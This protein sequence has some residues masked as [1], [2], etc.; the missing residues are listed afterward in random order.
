[1][2]IIHQFLSLRMFKKFD[3]CKHCSCAD[4][5][6]LVLR[7]VLAAVLVMHGYQKLFGGM[8]MFVGF[9]DKLQ[10]PMPE[11]L[12]WIVA[13]LE[14]VGGIAIAAGVYTRYV[15]AAVAVQFAVILLVVKKLAFPSSDTDLLVFGIA[16]ALAMVG[17]GSLSCDAK[18]M[19]GGSKESP[20]PAAGGSSM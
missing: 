10:F 14:F 1:M 9:L 17:A 18:F 4:Q 16:M 13:L 20:T 8:P 15:A 6:W 3:S 5:A 12:A 7:L 19:K 11:V 2:A